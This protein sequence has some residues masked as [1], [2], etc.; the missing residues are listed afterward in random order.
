MISNIYLCPDS[1]TGQSCRTI[2]MQSECKRSRLT[3]VVFFAW[4]Y[5]CFPLAQTEHVMHVECPKSPGGN[6]KMVF[7]SASWASLIIGA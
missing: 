7:L 4:C 3:V 6:L 2:S 1:E 5:G